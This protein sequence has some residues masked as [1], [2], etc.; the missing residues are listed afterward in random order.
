MKKHELLKYA[1]DN[2]P[3]GTVITWSGHTNLKLSGKYSFD[4]NNNGYILDDTCL[5]VYDGVRWAEIV[6]QEAVEQKERI[7]KSVS[8][9]WSLLGQ[10]SYNYPAGTIA[11]SANSGLNFKSS[12]KYRISGKGHVIDL[13]SGGFYFKSDTGLWANIIIESPS[14]AG[15]PTTVTPNG[16]HFFIDGRKLDMKPTEIVQIYEAYQKL[17]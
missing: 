7:T 12:G 1:Y 2:Y 10:A 17:K 6:P 3:A 5:C 4:G 9:E 15:Y 16:A 13:V 11:I 14:A 8:P